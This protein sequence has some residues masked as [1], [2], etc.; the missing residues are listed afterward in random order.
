LEIIAT[1][2]FSL[3]L[4]R[5]KKCTI[6]VLAPALQ[7]KVETIALAYT[8]RFVQVDNF[9]A[10][11]NH[12]ANACSCLS[13]TETMQIKAKNTSLDPKTQGFMFVL[14]KLRTFI[15]QK[16]DL[17]PYRNSILQK[18]KFQLNK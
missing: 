17:S 13:E 1:L 2:S 11:L 12:R 14:L 3:S 5:A 18:S 4:S 6:L 15:F 10:S 9:Q 16:C 7:T 8:R